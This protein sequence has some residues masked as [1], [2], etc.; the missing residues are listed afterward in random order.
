[1]HIIVWIFLFGHAMHKTTL[2]KQHSPLVAF[3]IFYSNIMHHLQQYNIICNKQHDFCSGFSCETQLLITI[4]DNV[5]NLNNYKQTD[6]IL[7]GFI[8]VV[9]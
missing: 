1:M 4:H 5:N 9:I 2:L 3:T 7:L 6:T 8:Q